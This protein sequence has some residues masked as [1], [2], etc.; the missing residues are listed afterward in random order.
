MRLFEFAEK[1]VEINGNEEIV[2]QYPQAKMPEY[3]TKKSAGADFFCAE[4]VVIPPSN[5]EVVRNDDGTEEYKFSSKP[6]LVHTGIRASM[7]DNEFLMLAN[8]SSNPGKGLIL[9]NGIGVVDA[10]YYK[11]EKNDGE[12]MFA[13]YNIKSEPVHI[14]VGDK[15]GQGVFM[16]FLRADNAI[17]KDEVRTGGH[18]STDK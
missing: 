14:K 6:V 9:A 3:A 7:N 15:L 8:R 16:P 4:D 11:C 17:I 18:G 1:T 12:I 5:V 10:D 13:F 2:R